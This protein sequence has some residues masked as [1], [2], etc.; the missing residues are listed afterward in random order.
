MKSIGV[1]GTNPSDV[2]FKDLLTKNMGRGGEGKTKS[3]IEGRR[4]KETLIVNKGRERERERDRDREKGERQ[5]ER[6]R[7]WEDI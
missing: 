1:V 2:F 3:V 7:G 4:D 6:E 5:R